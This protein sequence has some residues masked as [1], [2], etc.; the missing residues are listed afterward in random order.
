MAEVLFQ[1]EIDITVGPSESD[2]PQLE[3]VGNSEAVVDEK[4]MKTSQEIGALDDYSM[5]RINEEIPESEESVMIV[6]AVVPTEIT[7]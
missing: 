6:E 1:N 3:S 4:T 5:A 7:L 2:S